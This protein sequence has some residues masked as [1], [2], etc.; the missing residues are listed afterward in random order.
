MG[1]ACGAL[2]KTVNLAPELRARARRKEKSQT[3]ADGGA[4]SHTN[5]KLGYPSLMFH[6]QTS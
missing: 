5:H 1:R 3:R 6:L 2:T 4:G